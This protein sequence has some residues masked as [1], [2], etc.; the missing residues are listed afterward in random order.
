MAR[1]DAV[2]IPGGGLTPSGELMPFVRERLRRAA[3]HEAEVYIALSGGTTHAPPPLDARGYPILEAIPGAKYL[4]ELGIAQERILTET[5]SF[6]TIGNAFFTRAAHTDPRGWRRLLIVNSEF[7]MPRTEAIFRWV[8]GAAPAHGYELTFEAT[9]NEGLEGAA[10]EAR[11]KRELAS[12]E[13]VRKLA[14]RITTLSELHQWIYS[15][16]GAYAWFLREGAFRALAG[17][18]AESYGA[19]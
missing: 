2:L 16:H 5:F 12:L 9:R 1:F 6:D 7:H 13:E 10:L 18:I 3:Q 17:P 11:R 19:K 15:E 4:R 14:D 8:F